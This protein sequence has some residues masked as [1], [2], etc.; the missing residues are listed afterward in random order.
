MKKIKNTIRKI[1]R[2]IVLSQKRSYMFFRYKLNKGSGKLLIQRKNTRG[3]GLTTMMIKDC[4]K[5]GYYLFVPSLRDKYVISK[6]TSVLGY[7]IKVLVPT[8]DLH[9][10]KDLNVIIDNHCSFADVHKWLNDNGNQG[11][12]NIVNGFVYEPLAR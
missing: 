3:L 8:D 9:G 2:N 11:R 5:N 6:M 1:C 10:K 7:D 12:I 4:K